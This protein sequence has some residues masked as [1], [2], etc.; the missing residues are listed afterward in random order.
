M[1]LQVLFNRCEP[2]LSRRGSPLCISAEFVHIGSRHYVGY[3]FFF[4]L[5]MAASVRFRLQ[6]FTFPPP[7]GS[8]LPDPQAVELQI[9]NQSGSSVAYNGPFYHSSPSRHH[10][11]GHRP[12]KLQRNLSPSTQIFRHGKNRQGCEG[13]DDRKNNVWI[14][15]TLRTTKEEEPPY[16]SKTVICP[17]QRC[18][19]K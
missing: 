16:T 2:F 1:R 14:A 8:F 5:Q 9:R 18:R 12:I 17:V 3:L 4:F 19:A 6:S 13:H 11:H 10:S 7:V 15:A